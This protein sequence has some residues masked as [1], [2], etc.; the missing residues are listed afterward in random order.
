MEE[1]NKNYVNESEE[2][3][4]NTL[5]IS[6]HDSISVSEKIVVDIIVARIT[7]SKVKPKGSNTVVSVEE[8]RKLLGDFTSSDERVEERL[9]YLESFVRNIIK[10]E[11]QKIYE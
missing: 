9:Q 7:T 8:Y 10:P 4:K 11:L 1:L 6:V 5:F 2:T 3:E